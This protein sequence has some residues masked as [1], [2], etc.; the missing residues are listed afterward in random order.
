[1]NTR[2]IFTLFRPYPAAGCLP[3]RTANAG[4]YDPAAALRRERA[5][6]SKRISSASS[7]TASAVRRRPAW[8][9]NGPG[10]VRR[11][12]PV[13][14]DRRVERDQLQPPTPLRNVVCRLPGASAREIVLIAHH[15]IAPTTAPGADND[16]RRHRHPAAPGGDVPAEASRPTR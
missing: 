7:P 16:G 9:P 4:Q 10:A 5:Y 15:D 13:L 2:A 8:L 6:A 14:P 11:L 1:M 12:R 3:G